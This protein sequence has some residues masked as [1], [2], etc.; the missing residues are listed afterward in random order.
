MV[1]VYKNFLPEDH[2]ADIQTLFMTGALPWFFSDRVVTTDKHFM[3]Q[4]VFMDDGQIINER[5][6]S[7]AGHVPALARLRN[8]YQ[9]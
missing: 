7:C 2:F 1:D 3:F 4:H 6:S 8:R 5:F 9:E